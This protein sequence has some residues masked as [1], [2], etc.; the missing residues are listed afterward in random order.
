MCRSVQSSKNC[1]L[2]FRPTAAPLDYG[3]QPLPLVSCHRGV[4]NETQENTED[5][6]VAAIRRG[7]PIIDLNVMVT[8]YGDLVCN[9]DDNIRDYLV[10]CLSTRVRV[11]PHC[12]HD[13]SH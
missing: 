13:A 9:H 12:R 11:L 2:E 8:R 5:G 10:R 3:N 1:G 7:I 4:M 6:I